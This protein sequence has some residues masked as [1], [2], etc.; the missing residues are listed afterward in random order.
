MAYAGSCRIFAVGLGLLALACSNGDGDDPKDC[1][2]VAAFELTVRAVPGPLPADTTLEVQYG[3]G[4]E[5]FRLDQGVQTQEVVLCDETAKDAGAADGGVAE[6]HC[7]LWTQGAAKV[8]VTASGYPT[9]EETL[10]AKAQ[11][12]CIQ[13]VPVEIVLGDADGGT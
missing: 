8:T 1:K 12:K 6:V 7:R 10:E 5:T 11:G 13:T 4:T 9:V 2:L 3:G